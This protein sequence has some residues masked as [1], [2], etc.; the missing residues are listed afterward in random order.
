[1]SNAFEKIMGGEMKEMSL[2]ELEVF[3]AAFPLMEIVKKYYSADCYAETH[4]LCLPKGA[5]RLGAKHKLP[6]ITALA[7]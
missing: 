5:H 6:E 2:E 1:M 7:S 3:F 4:L